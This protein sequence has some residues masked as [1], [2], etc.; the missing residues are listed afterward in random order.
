MAAP[1]SLDE[2][3]LRDA[4]AAVMQRKWWVVGTV[5]VVVMAAL[6]LSY[7]QTPRYAASAEVLF[8]QTSAP[9][10]IEAAVT[11][12]NPERLLNTEVR[13]IE[14]QA[15]ADAVV[16]TL[17]RPA[18][19]AAAGDAGADVI[20]IRA[21]A[22]DPVVA[23]ETANVW[24]QTYIDLRRQASL[25]EYEVQAEVIQAKIDELD[26]QI[27]GLEAEVASLLPFAEGGSDNALLQSKQD[28]IQ[29]LTNEKAL[30]S[31]KLNN[32]SA[33]ADLLSGNVPEI[34]NEAVVPSSAYEPATAR[35]VIMAVTFGLLLGVGLALLIDY[36]DDSVKSKEDLERA[37][38]GLATL[39]LIPRSSAWR[40]RDD[41]HLESLEAPTSPTA[42]AYRSLRTALQFK[43]LERPLKTILVTSPRAADG[44]TTTVANLAVALSRADQRVVVL[45]CDLRR[46]RLQDFFHLPNTVGFTSVLVGEATLASA[47]QSVP[48]TEHLVVLPSGPVPPNPSELLSTDRTKEIVA[49]F[50]EETDVVLIDSPPV[51]PVADALVLSDI[52]DGVLL[53]ASA[54]STSRKG[55]ARACELLRAVNA[56]LIGTVLSNADSATSYE[57][58]YGYYRLDPDRSSRVR[59]RRA[60]RETSEVSSG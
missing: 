35:N 59:S 33:Q 47:L 31:T 41:A 12:A 32:L 46:P 27:D 18:A 16:E 23:A 42:E 49:L 10:G 20:R 30:W 7:L 2:R 19:A 39:A 37:S 1:D 17:G 52:V 9:A 50:C 4:L 48:G 3:D 26:Q 15:V 11:P 8:R 44:K 58:S 38:G 36:L 13:F 54:R 29:A 6:A 51:L 55:V 57:E 43:S 24:A 45:S 56:P 60:R 14:S 28:E 25:H 5:S 40:S 34:L 53:V 21:T 22:T